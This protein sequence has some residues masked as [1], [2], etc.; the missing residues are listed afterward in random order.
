MNKSS[1]NVKFRWLRLGY[2]ENDYASMNVEFS[3]VLYLGLV[4][5]Y[6]HGWLAGLGFSQIYEKL[7]MRLWL[8]TKGKISFR[9]FWRG[10]FL[11]LACCVGGGFACPMA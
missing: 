3:I 2:G 7:P 1:A 10:R 11:L 8:I 4:C 9:H 6:K 5:S